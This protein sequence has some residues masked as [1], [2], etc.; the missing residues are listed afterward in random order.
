MPARPQGIYS[1]YLTLIVD[2]DAMLTFTST[3]PTH[4]TTSRRLGQPSNLRFERKRQMHPHTLLPWAEPEIDSKGALYE[5]LDFQALS[6][7]LVMAKIFEIE[8]VWP[9]P[10]LLVGK[11]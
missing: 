6:Q 11:L 3:K 8:I 4:A 1:D 2:A 7:S 9:R 10:S 5:A